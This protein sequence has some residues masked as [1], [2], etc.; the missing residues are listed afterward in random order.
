MLITI[1]TDASW[2]PKEK[3][4]GYAFW[5]SSPWGK[6][7]KWGKL[8][9]NPLDSTAAEIMTMC[10][11]LSYVSKHKDLK[12]TTKII[13][14]TDSSWGIAYIEKGNKRVR[15]WDY[16]KNKFKSILKKMDVEVEFRDIKA[17]QRDITQPRLWVNAWADKMAK[18][19]RK[20]K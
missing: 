8:R 13:F 16:P 12:G 7:K 10:N 1:N 15:Q 3:C 14:N 20:L 4:G 2:C 17:H 19:G 9:L 6:F 11:A 18:Q 5:I